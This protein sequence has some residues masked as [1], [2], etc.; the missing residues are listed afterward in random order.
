[1]IRVLVSVAL[2]ALLAA[3]SREGI[4]TEPTFN[5]WSYKTRDRDHNRY[6]GYQDYHVREEQW[7]TD[8]Y[9]TMG[10]GLERRRAARAKAGQQTDA[11]PTPQQNIDMPP[12]RFM[13]G[14]AKR[15]P[16]VT[17]APVPAEDPN[18]R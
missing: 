12:E 13:R 7:Q 3:C 10:E 8:P 16:K 5:D 1:M 2:L 6:D 18:A 11:V 4:Q 15:T 9:W 17:A 14:P